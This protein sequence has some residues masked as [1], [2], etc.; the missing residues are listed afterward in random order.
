MHRGYIKFWR[1][2]KDSYY[3]KDSE[4]I[5]LWLHLLLSA[6]HKDSEI[7]YK[8]KKMIIKRGQLMT[9][10]NSLSQETGI[11]K[12]K[13]YRILKSLKNEQ[14]IEQQNFYTFTLIS[15]VN[16]G[17]HQS[18]E[19]R[20]EQ[21]VNSKRTASEQQVNTSKECKNDKNNNN[22]YNAEITTIV[23]ML[24]TVVGSNY[25]PTTAL[26]I[27]YISGRLSEKF[28][29]NDFEKVIKYQSML[30]KNDSK[31]SQYLTPDTLFRPSNFE[32]Y[33]QNANR[34]LL[35]Q[36][37]ELLK[38]KAIKDEEDWHENRIRKEAERENCDQ[39]GNN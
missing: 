26:T 31:M 3:Y 11:D 24:N 23:N 16:Y 17:D 8:D 14:Q 39:P 22:I 37:K 36:K 12:S 27:K 21:Q 15:I 4:Y 19:Q 20:N 9:G 33:L 38:P 34:N 1:K 28:T 13:V 2:I 30:W 35:N 7:L 5:H 6:N 25:R 29:V 32:K 18:N 10:R